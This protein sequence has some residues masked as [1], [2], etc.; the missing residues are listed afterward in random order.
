MKKLLFLLLPIFCL[1]QTADEH[2]TTAQKLLE[3]GNFRKADETI[4]KAIDL[5]P[6]NTEYRWL[7]VRANLI[8]NAHQDKL[9]TAVENLHFIISKNVTSAKIY[10]ALGIAENGI[11]NEIYRYNH[12]K[13]DTGFTDNNNEKTEQIK[14][15][16]DAISHFKAAIN[17]FE[18]ANE[19]EKDY[20]SDKIRFA[21]QDIERLEKLIVELK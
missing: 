4:S 15:Y 13:K 19:I 21:K 20:S 3:Q 2:Y 6:E 17:A 14:I 18:K 9:N 10:N 16:E 8:S 5:S 12:P 7:K 1:S 11:A